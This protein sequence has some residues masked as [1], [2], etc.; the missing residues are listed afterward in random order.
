V[1][2]IE[3]L[4]GGGAPAGDE[5]S[6][7]AG[8]IRKIAR[9]LGNLEPARAREFAA[10]AF[11]LSRVAHSDLDISEEE[12]RAMEE[13]VRSWGGLPEEQAALVVQIAK[14]QNILFG[15][16][17]NFIVT[18][19]FNQKA[20]REQKIRLMHCIFAVSAADDSI[21]AVEE[22]S[23]AQI[24]RELGFTH[25]EMVAIRSLYS[26]KRAVLRSEQEQD[27]RNS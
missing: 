19:E 27:G 20:S 26:D 17:D 7:E 21:S 23:I 24:A 25:T 6:S 16:T 5:P 13:I 3:K 9:E 10:F 22:G 15:G 11:I 4:F 2:I 8:T 1:S 18:R 14:H 12:V